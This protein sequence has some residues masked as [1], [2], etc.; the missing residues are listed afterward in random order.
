MAANNNPGW[1]AFSAAGARLWQ[2]N[3]QH[4]EAAYKV[5]EG[6]LAT[7]EEMAAMRGFEPE[8]T[9]LYVNA[10]DSLLL[11]CCLKSDLAKDAD[12]LGWLVQKIH[13]SIDEDEFLK[14]HLLDED[15][16]PI[17]PERIIFCVTKALAEDLRDYM[18]IEVYPLRLQRCVHD[19]E[20]KVLESLGR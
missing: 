3:P 18:A 19:R 4:L 15:E 8:I 11:A 5:A 14:D 16:E 9:S 7:P 6:L 13:S 17:I 12:K 10:D 2:N 1:K 20:C